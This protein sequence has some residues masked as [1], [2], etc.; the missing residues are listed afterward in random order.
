M[1]Y[2]SHEK[3]T[4]MKRALFVVVC[5]TCLFLSAGCVS[6]DDVLYTSLI[7]QLNQKFTSAGNAL[8][9]ANEGNE[10]IS[11]CIQH[12][13][14]LIQSLEDARTTMMGLR[15]SKTYA[16]S[17]DL[18]VQGINGLLQSHA[19]L[20][21]VNTADEFS[22]WLADSH[23]SSP[24]Q[25]SRYTS[26]AEQIDRATRMIYH[27]EPETSPQLDLTNTY[28]EEMFLA[29]KQASDIT[30]PG[31]ISQEDSTSETQKDAEYVER[32]SDPNLVLYGDLYADSDRF[33]SL[34]FYV[35][36]PDKGVPV[37]LADIDIF[38]GTQD[39]VPKLS[40]FYPGSG[41]LNPGE[42][43]KI[44]LSAT[45][46]GAGNRFTIEIKPRGGASEIFAKTLAQDYTGGDIL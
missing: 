29:A 20:V 22:H 35:T 31:S 10:S 36:I 34:S 32:I 43:T 16:G 33:S 42:K 26:A 45:G 1:F 17:R 19:G 23:L 44:V 21:E 30:N 46:P 39:G 40:T 8:K 6:N 13:K 3:Y 5:V 7:E 11:S 41:L 2:T 15:L 12:E 14:D 27:S 18:Y 37:N 28:V 24:Q 4:T 25:F 38:Y 9:S